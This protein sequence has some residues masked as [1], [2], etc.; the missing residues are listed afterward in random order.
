MQIG[1]CSALPAHRHSPLGELLGLCQ[2]Q[3]VTHNE[4]PLTGM[5]QTM[6]LRSMLASSSGLAVP[7]LAASFCALKNA[8][9]G[10]LRVTQNSEGMY[11]F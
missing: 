5:M 10:E 2:M 6:K 7:D 4:R 3:A 1:F 8:W 11:A 9:K